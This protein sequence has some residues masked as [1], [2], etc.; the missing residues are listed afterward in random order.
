MF[1]AQRRN[2]PVAHTDLFQK[3]TTLCS[4]GPSSLR[5]PHLLTVQISRIQLLV[6]NRHR[7]RC[8]VKAAAVRDPYEQL[9]LSSLSTSKMRGWEE[10]PLC[11][12]RWYNN[13]E[14]EA[15]WGWRKFGLTG[16]VMKYSQRPHYE[17]AAKPTQPKLPPTQ[18][19]SIHGFEAMSSAGTA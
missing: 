18:S 11:K 16:W 1:S 10:D 3:K 5:T 19:I 15:G 9:D 7:H 14:I 12:R 8:V 2:N 17:P 4:C 13:R 6:P